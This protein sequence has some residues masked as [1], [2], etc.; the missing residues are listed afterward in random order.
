MST[1]V[2]ETSRNRFIDP[3]ILVKIQ[4]LELVA[5]TVVEGFVS[6]LHRSPFLGFSVDFAEYRDYNPGDDLRRID[7]NVYSRMDKLVVKLFEGETNTKSLILLDAS[8]S[9]NYGSKGVT[10]IDYARFLAASLAYFAYHQR[11]GVGL[12]TFDTG[13][14]DYV[15]AARRAGQLPNILHTID[16]LTSSKETEFRKPLRHLAEILKRRGLIVVISDLYDEPENIM[17]G[18]KQLKAKGNDIIVFHIMDDFELTFPFEEHAQFE[19]LETQ[20][21]MHVIPEY[22]RP[23]YLEILGQHMKQLSAEM[24]ANRIDYTLM[25]TSK[26]LDQG[27]FNYLAARAKTV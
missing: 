17:A 26:P 14:R 13:V 15:P 23:Q 1:P 24:A 4:N 3:K 7:W 20:K 5:R 2:V 12:L 16:R 9:M 11:D 19:D 22:L 10:K 18:L 27:L 8:G 21:K 6:G 25:N